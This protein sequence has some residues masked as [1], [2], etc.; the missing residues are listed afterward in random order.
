MWS[1]DNRSNVECLPLA[2]ETS[3]VGG[4]GIQHHFGHVGTP[5]DYEWINT[6]SLL[7]PRESPTQAHEPARQVWILDVGDSRDP[8][9]SCF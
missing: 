2:N 3:R 4:A 6:A 1:D 5:R 9:Q 8:C 7:K